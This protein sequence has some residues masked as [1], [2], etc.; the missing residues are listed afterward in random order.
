MGLQADD[1]RRPAAHDGEQFQRRRRDHAQGALSADEQL[2]QVVAGVVLPQPFQAVEHLTVGHDDLQAQHQVA[3]HAVA[4]H[5]RA[6]GVGRDHAADG[7][8]ALGREAE[9][10]ESVLLPG[11]FLRLQQGY[12]RLD[13]HGVVQRRH[14]AHDAQLARRQQH[15]A[16]GNLTA[17]QAGAAALGD[18][19]HAV[20]SADVHG[21]SNFLGRARLQQQRRLAGPATAP[22]GEPG[23]HFTGVLR[24]G[25][26]QGGLEFGEGFR[27]GE[28]HIRLVAKGA[29]WWKRKTMPSGGHFKGKT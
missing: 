20:P 19:R 15:L 3:H 10:E 5:R 9:R 26:G 17:D 21:A 11:Q 16:I 12:A 18:E 8:R 27:R 25:A 22:F 1:G 6:A 29:A 13:R 4:Q 2:L 23:R 24:P 7:G 28:G 14:V